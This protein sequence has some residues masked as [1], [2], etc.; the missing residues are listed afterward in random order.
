MPLV[1]KPYILMRMKEIITCQLIEIVLRNWDDV[2][3]EHRESADSHFDR[4][5]VR[6]GRTFMKQTDV[7]TALA[8]AV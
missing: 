6:S 1:K 3:P 5:V 8:D 4:V 2:E 7:C